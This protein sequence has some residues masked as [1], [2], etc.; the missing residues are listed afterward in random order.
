MFAE[1]ILANGPGCLMYRVGIRRAFRNL[2]TDVLDHP[3]LC[4]KHNDMYYVD[5]SV[6]NGLRTGS[7]FM[8]RVTDSIRIMGEEYDIHII[9]YIDDLVS[10]ARTEHEAHVALGLSIAQDKLDPPSNCQ[11][12]LGVPFDSVAMTMSVPEK[13]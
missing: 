5:V 12:F 9:N 11:I 10:S 3:L 13:T 2:R 1:M 7:M 6:A 4:I 8:Q